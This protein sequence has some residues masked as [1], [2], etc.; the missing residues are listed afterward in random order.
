LK[1]ER[2]STKSELTLYKTLIIF[3]MNYVGPTWE[4]AAD[5]HVLKLQPL[6][7]RVLRNIANLPRRTVTRDLHQ[8]FQIPYGHD[9]INKNV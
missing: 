5:S 8:A 6:Q 7:N 2:L 9:Y 4:F 1:S 3:K